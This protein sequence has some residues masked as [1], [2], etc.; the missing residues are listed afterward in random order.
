[1]EALACFQSFSATSPPWHPIITTSDTFLW[2]TAP[3][4]CLS[5]MGCVLSMEMEP[6]SLVWPMMKR[7]VRGEVVFHCSKCVLNSL[8]FVQPEGQMC[9]GAVG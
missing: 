7:Q 1:M 6:Y 3:V 8:W 5:K 2:S 4:H 9:K